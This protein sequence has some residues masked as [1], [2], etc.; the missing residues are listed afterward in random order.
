MLLGLSF[1]FPFKLS[2]VLVCI[3]KRNSYTFSPFLLQ[4]GFKRTNK[5]IDAVH[6]RRF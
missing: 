6:V 1:S 4:N 3:K 2:Y 5:K